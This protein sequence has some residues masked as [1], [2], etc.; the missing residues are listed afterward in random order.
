[1]INRPTRSVTRFFIPLIDVLILLFC[2]FLLLPVV[3]EQKRS[4]EEEK[5]TADPTSV[6]RELQ[7]VK[8]ELDRA[9]KD[10][11]QL[12]AERKNPADRYSICVL[13]ID[14][15]DGSLIYYRNGKPQLVT[16]PRSA[17]DVI[18]THKLLTPERDPYFVILMPRVL[19]GFPSGPQVR[20]FRNWFRDVPLRID[21]PF[22]LLESSK[23]K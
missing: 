13:D 23:E 1:V 2:M 14:P 6:E 10:V 15:K 16:D 4:E 9:R 22:G 7:A 12:Q 3:S 8:A 18:D 5:K 20:Q 11:A 19:S 21:S 17:Q